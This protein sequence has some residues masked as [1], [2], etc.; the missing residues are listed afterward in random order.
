V[1][2]EVPHPSP[3]GFAATPSPL[4]LGG[5]GEGAGGWGEGSPHP[6]PGGFAATPS[7]LPLG[8][9][10]EGAG[11]WG[12][13]SPHP[14]PA[15]SAA[16]P[17]PLPLGGRGEGAGGWGEGSPHPSPAASGA[18]PS[19][20]LT[21]SQERGGGRGWG[22][23]DLTKPYFI[24]QAH[25]PRPDA[26]SPKEEWKWEERESPLKRT[27]LYETHKR[28]GA[29]MVPFAGWEMPVWYT[30]VS[31]EHR[32]VRE[33]AGLFDVAHMGVFEVAG[34]HATA[35]LDTVCSNYVAWLEDGQSLY[36]Y[37]L[38]PDANVIDDIMVYRR[39]ADLYLVVVNAAN[40]EKDWDWLNAVNERRVVID[41]ARPWVQVEAPA[42][43]RNLKDPAS[44]E[45]QKRD[46]AL[47]GPASLPTLL[48]LAD[49]A[50]FRT[51]LSRLRRT[52][53]LEGSLAGIP[54][55]IARTGY[56]GE[57]WGYEIFVHPDQAPALWDR[58]LEAGERFGVKPAGLG[59]RDSTR[60]E[61]GLPLYG[62]EL[63]GPFH[64]SPIEAGFAG[65]VKYHKPFFIGRDALL[66]REKGR[67]RELIRFRVAEK[68][69]RRPQT[70]DPVVN[71]KGQL[72]GHVT[73]C[74][75]DV[76]G[77]LVGLAIVKKQYNVPGTPIAIFPLGGK[78]LE[79]ATAADRAVLPVEATVLTRFRERAMEAQ[80]WRTVED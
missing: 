38:D 77:Y 9:R 31:E 40:E 34:P 79:E 74:S 45:R 53:L 32:A 22:E 24:G 68:G 47:Q 67:E 41:R 10:G 55:V 15:A 75:I 7:P 37:L 11:G 66:A 70:G 26:P 5:R 60:T 2:E 29:K 33:T 61:A 62:H 16:T 63:A 59:A 25:L 46:I 72:I 76:E 28:M 44:G 56:T 14:S 36:G 58:I 1:V 13:G 8:G 48:A 17:S 73:S 49:G 20:L 39:R 71:R 51:A 57:E 80:V 42:I 65:Y 4:P 19:P 35:F 18:T 21:E 43:L 6:S 12:E 3:G 54:V 69:V 52:D 50:E 64:I 30:S 27:P 78:S 23:V